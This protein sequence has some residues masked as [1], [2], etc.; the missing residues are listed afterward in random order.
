MTKANF[1]SQISNR[2]SLVML[3]VMKKLV[4]FVFLL[5]GLAVLLA[6]AAPLAGAYLLRRYAS[7]EFLV[8]EAEKHINARVELKE[9]TLT[10]FT[11]TPSLRLSGIKIAPRDDFAG[12]PL[13]ERPPLV[14]APVNIDMAYAELVPREL[15]RRQFWPRIIRF[16]G[17][18]V[19][20]SISAQN[21]SSLRG[22]F[23]RP[24][25]PMTE[26]AG[27]VP[28]AIPVEQVMP[29]Q[30]PAPAPLPPPTTTPVAEAPR[31]KSRVVR[32]ALQDIRI[33]QGRFRIIN[34][35]ANSGFEGE[36]SDFNLSISDID[37][38]PEDIGRHN[39][40]TVR[41]ESKVVFDG[42]AQVNGSMQK[43]RFADM[44]LQGDGDVNPLNPATLEWS[45]A[46]ILKL[47]IAR[48]SLVGGH[49]TIGDAAGDN[50]D[51]LMKYGVDLRGIRLGGPLAQNLS[52]NVL[53]RQQSIKFL[54]DTHLALPDYEVTVKKESWIDFA[55]DNQ[56][57][58]TRLYCRDALKEQIVRGVA[59]RGLGDNISRMVVDGL[60]DDQGRL[61]FDLSV[62][63]SLS[64]PVAKPD[65]QL[66]LES[67]LGGDIEDKAKGL[68]DTFKGLKGLFKK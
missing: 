47:V 31:E 41:V 18:D 36:L 61:S 20:E 62:T 46:A 12:K 57:L 5:L 11:F 48:D 55:A 58:L 21:G 67:L 60:S 34:E 44:K 17:V 6:V 43:V 28:R 30:Q 59:A 39:H 45:P 35:T 54:E 7:P 50:L 56:G 10:L 40:F 8:L 14:N 27:E 1:K 32:L 51:K 24:D 49:M 66:R 52:V 25:E 16:I 19:T 29:P 13:A 9:V 33:E 68:I 38:D 26:I 3:A 15:L 37:I 53:F 42:V 63:G 65:I 23:E 22:L 4:R 64:R 2:A